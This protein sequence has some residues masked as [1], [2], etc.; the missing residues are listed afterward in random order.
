MPTQSFTREQVRERFGILTGL[1]DAPEDQ[2][3]AP[4]MKAASITDDTEQAM[5]LARE[6]LAGQGHV[7]PRRWADALDAWEQRMRAAGSQDLLGP[8]T[9][10]A[11]ELIR[12]GAEPATAGSHGTTNGAAMRIAPVG[13][14]VAWGQ[15][16]QAQET[17]LDYVEEA[18]LPTHHTSLAIAGAAAVA[19]AVSAG[20]AGA[21]YDDVLGAA[22]EASRRG[23]SRGR[24]VPGPSVGGRIDWAITQTEAMEPDA[25]ADWIYSVLGTTVATQESVP[26]AFAL[27]RTACAD[28]AG[29]LL[30]AASLGGDTDTIAAMLGAMTGAVL[31]RTGL[32]DW[33]DVVESVNDLHLAALSHDLLTLRGGLR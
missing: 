29:G 26:A 13:I 3:I 32:P 8:S 30:E 4:G 19:A 18:C 28:P 15:S 25:R 9:T 23:E 20:V 21:S 22:L 11:I 7:D 2:P 14:A 17:F 33:T 5:L 27:L 12:G 1:V 6:V 31:G 10:R 16:A 24:V